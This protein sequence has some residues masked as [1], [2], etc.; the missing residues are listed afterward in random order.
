[1]TTRIDWNIAKGS[2]LERVLHFTMGIFCWPFDKSYV[3]STRR[4]CA[5]G[6][7]INQ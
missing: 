2:T 4:A 3:P 5:V 1:M 7:C 6:L